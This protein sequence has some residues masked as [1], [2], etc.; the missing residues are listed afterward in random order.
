MDKHQSLTLLMIFCPAD[1]NL[2][3]Q[4]SERLHQADDSDRGRDSQLS[5]LK[6]MIN[7]TGRPIVSTT[8][9]LLGALSD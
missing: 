3:W 1:R 9:D 4:S 2:T 6:E 8:L 7:L 5:V